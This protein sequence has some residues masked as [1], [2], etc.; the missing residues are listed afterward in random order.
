MRAAFQ[1]A[2]PEWGRGR[3]VVTDTPDKA[4]ELRPPRVALFGTFD[5]PNFGDCLFPLVVRQQISRRLKSVEVLAFSP[6]SRIPSTADYARVYAFSELA[7]AFKDHE[8]AA[9][10][11]GGGALLATEH[12]LFSYPQIR[13]RYPYS[14]KCWLLP[15]MIAS[16]W[17]TPLVL[18]GIGIGPFD[19]A[20]DNLA[21]TYL[22]DA[23]IPGVRDAITADYLRRLGLSPE[24][25]PD[26]GVLT[27]GLKSS[28]EWEDSFAGIKRRLGLPDKY[29]AVQAS[30]FLGADLER[31]GA[32][33][34][35]SLHTAGLPVVLLPICRHLNDRVAC[36]ILR[37]IFERAG[38]KTVV[39]RE[40][41][42]S[43]ET[44]AILRKAA[45]FVGTSLHG[46]LVTLAFG[47]PAVSFSLSHM[48][49]NQAVLDVFA[50]ANCCTHDVAGLPASIAAAMAAAQNQYARE[51]ERARKQLDLFFDRV[52]ALLSSHK[53]KCPK[54]PWLHMVRGEVVCEP[55]SNPRIEEDLNEVKRLSIEYGR[56]ISLS[57]RIGAVAI[58]NNHVASELYDRIMHWLAVR[59]DTRK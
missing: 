22:R 14:L 54:K 19:P 41:L 8:A 39:V 29:A 51:C 58:R 30:L 12:V 13:L 18:N 16:A 55:R 50:A 45:L 32:A 49:K 42:T 23:A 24:I 47:N 44:S 48:K 26:C 28:A 46:A 31:F 37:P 11:I 34:A 5:T 9:F 53:A 1:P 56:S 4:R 21:R 25:V 35:Q 57:R 36:G 38:V 3:T 17:E 7:E 33:A 52:C 27:P 43:L 6:T 59:R 15:A 20:Y 2:D 40:N 10:I